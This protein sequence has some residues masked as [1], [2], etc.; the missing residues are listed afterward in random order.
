MKRGWFITF[1]GPEGSGKTTQARRLVQALQEQGYRVVLTREPG[2]TPIGDQIRQVLLDHHNQRMHPRTEGLL[3]QAS[4]AQ[5]VAEVICPK[6][7]AGFVVVCDRFADSTLAYQGFGRRENLEELR[8]LIA[9]ATWGLAPHLTFLLDVPPETGLRR[10]HGAQPLPGEEW[11][12]LDAERLAF[13]R[14]VREGYR[15]LAQAEPSR[16]VVLDGERPIDELQRRILEVVATRLQSDA[17]PTACS[18]VRWT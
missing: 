15:A 6:L 2:G 17:P 16:W 18:R 10:R 4:R 9:Y 1:E 12:R 13:H 11:N 3:F 5:H 7:E 14:A 8:R